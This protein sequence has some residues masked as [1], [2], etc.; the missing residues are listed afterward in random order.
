[1]GVGEAV[2]PSPVGGRPVRRVV[3]FSGSAHQM[4]TQ[5]PT[6]NQNVPRHCPECPW[7][8]SIDLSP[9]SGPSG[10]VT[11]LML[12]LVPPKLVPSSSPIEI[13]GCCPIWPRRRLRC[14]DQ[15]SRYNTHVT[16]SHS[17]VL[18]KQKL[19][20]PSSPVAFISLQKCL[21]QFTCAISSFHLA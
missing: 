11:V 8:R 16:V 3:A 20:V 18:S 19:W 21:V 9:F 5:P 15:G 13:R 2:W 6:V 14:L 17:S 12:C 7:P 1:M 4:L 10:A